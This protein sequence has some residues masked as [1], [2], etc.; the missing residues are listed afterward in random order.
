MEVLQKSSPSLKL[1]VAAALEKYYFATY[2][3]RTIKFPPH[4]ELEATS[5]NFTATKHALEK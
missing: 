3:M 4:N 2:M 1:P 5:G